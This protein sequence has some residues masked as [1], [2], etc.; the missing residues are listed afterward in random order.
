L[1]FVLVPRRFAVAL[2]VVVLLFYGA[3]NRPV[4]GITHS[5]SVHSYIGGIR[6]PPRDWIDEA[7]GRNANVASLWWTGSNAVPYWES[8]FFNRSVNRAYT[9]SGPYDGLL[10]AFT[11]IQIRP[12][13][14]VLDLDSR[15]I[16]ERYV[17][18]DIGTRL[19]G[20]LVG[21]NDPV[22]LVVY[23]VDGPLTTVE[24]LDGL[25]PDYWTGRGFAYQRFDCE[26]ATLLLSIENNPLIHPAR[27]AV[28][29]FVNGVATRPLR[30]A[31]S[32]RRYAVSIPLRPQGGVC[33]VD[34]RMPVASA[35]VVT[36]GDF[37]ELGLRFLSVRYSPRR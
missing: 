6:H 5:A 34:L 19:R 14:A 32:P 7:V 18:T 36:P 16:R 4:E 11:R 10:H 30:F 33:A 24:R 37:R 1:V 20:R 23:E 31:P 15:P 28:P 25:Y 3:A 12:S 22:G 21:R 26:P 35:T 17:L 29:V 13:G 9:L 2:P 27:F 8:Q